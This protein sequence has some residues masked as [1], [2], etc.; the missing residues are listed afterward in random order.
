MTAYYCKD[1]AAGERH[2]YG[3]EAE[4]LLELE[5][6]LAD[7]G[8]EAKFDGEWSLDIES[9]TVGVAGLDAD[10]DFEDDVPTHRIELFG[11]KRKGFDARLAE[12]P[13]THAPAA[14]NA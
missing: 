5:E 9:V 13:A 3:T 7:Y 6:I 1:P 14:A 4:A 10:S 11:S 2:V 12:I 8:R